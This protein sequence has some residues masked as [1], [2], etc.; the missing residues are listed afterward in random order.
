MFAIFAIERRAP[1]DEA[2]AGRRGLVAQREAG[3]RGVRGRANRPAIQSHRE[4][5]SAP[6]E[7]PP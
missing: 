6:E 4:Q 1:V 3:M 5:Q 7:A 2:N